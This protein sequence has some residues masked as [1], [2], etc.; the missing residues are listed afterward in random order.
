[1]R[2]RERSLWRRAVRRLKSSRASAYL[3]YAV[4]LPLVVLSISALIEFAAFWDA[5]IMANHA[6]WTCARI[7]SVEA[8]EQGWPEDGKFEDDRLRTKGMTTATAMLMSTCAMGSMH[9][10]STDFVQSW[11]ETL[12]TKPLAGLKQSVADKLKSNPLKSSDGGGSILGKVK[13]MAQGGALKTLMESAGSMIVSGILDPIFDA[14]ASSVDGFFQPLLGKLENALDGNRA[15]RQFAYA[16]SR[17]AE[18]DGIVTVRERGD[19]AFAHGVSD[20]RLD[21]PR[22]LDG[23]AK[24]D[25]WFVLSDSPWPPNGQEQRMI[26]V[27]IR[28]PFERAWLFPVLST[29]KDAKVTSGR[30]TA[31]GRALFY[32]QPTIK[33]EHLKSEGAEAFASGNT[34]DVSAVT[35]VKDKY[36]GFMKVAALYYHYLLGDEEIGPYDSESKGSGSYK[37]IG[38][39]IS[40][41][42]EKGKIYKNDGLVFWMDRAPDDTRNHK[43]WKRKASP[44]DYNQCFRNVTGEKKETC[45]FWGAVAFASGK[46]SALKRF[47]R[48]AYRNREWFCWGNG[49]TSHLRFSHSP[50]LGSS[51][52]SAIPFVDVATKETRNVASSKELRQA[53]LVALP[54][55]REVTKMEYEA[56]A[57]VKAPYDAYVR[58]RDMDVRFASS[59]RA[60]VAAQYPDPDI[61]DSRACGELD[62]SAEKILFTEIPALHESTRALVKACSK[63]LDKAVNG[64]AADGV[65]GSEDS[66]VDVGGGD[67]EIMKDPKKAAEI[68]E[69]KMKVLR[70]KTFDAIAK[71]NQCER[72]LR[73]FSSRSAASGF[74]KRLEALMRKRGKD[75]VEFAQFTGQAIAESGGAGSPDAVW[76][77]LH[78]RHYFLGEEN[79]PLVQSEAFRQLALDAKKLFQDYHD[80][81]VELAKLFNLKAATTPQK[82]AD[83]PNPSLTGPDADPGLAPVPSGDSGSDNDGTGDSWSRGA[84]GWTRDGKGADR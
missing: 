13:G 31:V 23:K 22:C 11:Y 33:N 82:R 65:G 83:D 21:F 72:N 44:D 28:W 47:E 78:D 1:M 39:G 51:Y 77:A 76:N 61:G 75:V 4:V 67:D 10:S 49:R 8:G 74:E 20:R 58:M 70:E 59:V 36:V 60:M 45:Y 41:S 27:T 73:N 56:G 43:A 42:A 71:V 64:D 25:D 38:T 81:Q 62:R 9:G 63:E 53:F 57:G 46:K 37:G 30:P 80:A 12:V 54:L 24:C 52:L 79:G 32:P 34:N 40:G 6:A 69:K 68:I 5:K 3:E 18:D 17:V 19:M 48:H 29:A 14:I 66:F 16:W 7:A 55:G 50:G 2:G 15:L 26:D 35:K 84:D